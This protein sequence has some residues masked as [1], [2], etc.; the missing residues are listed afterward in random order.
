MEI[1][2]LI[3]DDEEDMRLLMRVLIEAADK[4]LFVSGEASRGR[5]ALDRIREL[6]PTVVV[7]DQMMPGMTGIETA[8]AIR[9]SRP[10]QLMLM[11][12]AYLDD[13]LVRQ[14]EQAGIKIC[15]EKGELEAIPDTVKRLA[16]QTA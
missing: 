2:V 16:R 4:G 12:S 5:E 14:A 6:D 11:C 3:V 7:L 15:L 10:W 9:R 8:T 1:G 13:D